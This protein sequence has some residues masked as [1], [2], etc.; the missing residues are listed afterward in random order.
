M[1][2]YIVTD[3]C[4]LLIS[5][6][7]IKDSWGSC[8][9]H[10]CSLFSPWIA[11]YTDRIRRWH[12]SCLARKYL[13]SRKY[14]ELWPGEGVDNRLTERVQRCCNRVWRGI[15]F[16]QTRSR[17]TGNVNGLEW[18]NCLGQTL[19][20][21]AVQPGRWFFIHTSKTIWFNLLIFS[22]K[23]KPWLEMHLRL[24]MAKGFL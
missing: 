22:L 13:S 15:N 11:C 3:L 5:C 16:N 8:T 20:N 4:V 12:S 21:A 7:W 18:K 24:K 10:C 19:W 17:R 2:L 9:E 6:F 1:T 14:I 23:R